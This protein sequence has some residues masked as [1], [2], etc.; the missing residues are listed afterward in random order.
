MITLYQ[1]DVECVSG[2]DLFYL[3][4]DPVQYLVEIQR[5]ANHIGCL[6]ESF[7]QLS[8]SAFG[9]KEATILY[10]DGGLP[11]QKKEQAN[12]V[13]AVSIPREFGA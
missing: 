4:Q 5:T 1:H 13:A 2:D 9:L 6:L 8:L 12:L 7:C 3:P 11:A 10:C